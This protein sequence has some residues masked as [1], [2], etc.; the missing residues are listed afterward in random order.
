MKNIA[1]ISKIANNIEKTSGRKRNINT[2]HL[3]KKK[4]AA[5]ARQRLSKK[6][7]SIR[8][9]TAQLIHD[10]N[11][12]IEIPCIF[13]KVPSAGY[14]PRW[15]YWSYDFF[16]VRPRGLRTQRLAQTEPGGEKIT[17][18]RFDPMILCSF[19]ATIR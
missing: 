9:I 15:I 5:A 13:S 10:K 18:P 19:L 1:R 11:T 7:G 3:G 6:E 16:F 17:F 8:D 4:L 14:N 2:E 12:S